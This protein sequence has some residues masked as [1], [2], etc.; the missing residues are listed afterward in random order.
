MLLHA[1]RCDFSQR[2]LQLVLEHGQ[3]AVVMRRAPAVS[4]PLMDPVPNPPP[5]SFD[6]KLTHQP[7]MTFNPTP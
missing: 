2:L 6:L 3:L 5:I 1:L 4:F 7:F